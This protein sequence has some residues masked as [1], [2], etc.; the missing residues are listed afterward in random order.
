MAYWTTSALLASQQR[1]TGRMTEAELRMLATPT[2]TA[3]LKNQAFLIPN[4]EELKKTDSRTNS[5]YYLNKASHTVGSARAH[6]HT[7]DKGSSTKIDLSWTTYAADFN[8]SLKNA[9]PN[10][11]EWKEMFDNEVKSALIDIHEEIEADAISWLSTYKSQVIVPSDSGVVDWDTSN[12][13][14]GV[15]ATDVD[16]FVQQVKTFMWENK[17]KGEFDLIVE[18]GLYVKLERALNQGAGNAENL[19]FQFDKVNIYPTSGAVAT[20]VTGYQALGYI[21]PTGMV[22]AMTWIPRL[23]RQGTQTNL[24]NYDSMPDLFGTGMDFATHVYETGADNSSKGG[25]L[26]D[27]DQEWEF[28]VDVSK[29]FAPTSTANEYPIFKVG[30]KI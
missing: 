5:T 27:V 15:N 1:I 12:Y 30:L 29:F 20:A 7:G 25:E 4:I 13:I 24:Y 11:F 26:Q 6:A 19:G 28:S 21:F 2:V 16:Y 17:Y 18:P 14:G 10:L 9:D 3:L 8:I 23:N 22:G